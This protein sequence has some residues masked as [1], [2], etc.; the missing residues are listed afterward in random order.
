MEENKQ[1]NTKRVVTLHGREMTLAG[2]EIKVGD[3]AP[4]FKVISNDLTPMKFY[5]T[6][7]G[8]VVLIS[9]VPSLDTPVCDLETRKFNDEAQKLS[10][11]VEIITISMDLPFAQ[12]R[13]CGQAGV[14]RVKTYS[15]YMKAELGKA[16]GVLIK[17]LRLLARCIFIIDREGTIRYIQLVKEISNEPNYEEAINTLKQIV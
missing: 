12:K 3:K 10:S 17:E 8:K 1:T 4:D 2:D 11:D 7:K 6:Y 15:D 5:R 14:E 9:S 16:Y 13:W